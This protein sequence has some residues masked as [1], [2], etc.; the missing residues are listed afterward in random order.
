MMDAT[1]LTALSGAITAGLGLYVAW[2]AAKGYVEHDSQTMGALAVGIVAI[3]VV[4]FLIAHVLDPLF[5]LSD[6]K[7][8]LGV[9]LSHTVG[10]LAIYQT[11]R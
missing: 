4:P 2:L 8:I 1:T 5:A 10:L 11:F 3:T 6:A 9:M 7:S